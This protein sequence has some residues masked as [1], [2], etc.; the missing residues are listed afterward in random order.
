MI[1]M[2]VTGVCDDV[3]IRRI[4]R[5]AAVPLSLSLSLCVFECVFVRV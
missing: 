1:R 3:G 5:R 2:F 4:P